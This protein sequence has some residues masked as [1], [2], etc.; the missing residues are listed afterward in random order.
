LLRKGVKHLF[1]A[2]LHIKN[3]AHWPC[4]EFIQGN[5]II[6]IETLLFSKTETF[7]QNQG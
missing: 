7:L 1:C 4:G 6:G 5:P 2:I 3:M